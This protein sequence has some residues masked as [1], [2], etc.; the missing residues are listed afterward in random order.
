[1]VSYLIAGMLAYGAIGWVIAHF[2]HIELFFPV[3]LA[4]GMAISLGWVVYRYGR[5]R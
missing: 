2:T 5:Q 1:M 3:G 4:V